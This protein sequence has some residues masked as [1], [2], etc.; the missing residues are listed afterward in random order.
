MVSVLFILRGKWKKYNLFIF[1][2]TYMDEK[3]NKTISVND[4]N[5]INN[6]FKYLIN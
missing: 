1:E 3:H 5:E 4:V 2:I 6:K